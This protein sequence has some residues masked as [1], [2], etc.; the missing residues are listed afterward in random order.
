MGICCDYLNKPSADP[1]WFSCDYH[2]FGE[3]SLSQ[4]SGLPSEVISFVPT[5][6]LT[7]HTRIVQLDFDTRKGKSG[8]VVHE[9]TKSKNPESLVIVG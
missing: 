8:A 7:Y 6:V 9:A 1:V 4:N 5:T 3:A 2:R